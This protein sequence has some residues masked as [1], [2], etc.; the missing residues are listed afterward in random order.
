MKKLPIG[1]VLMGMAAS[2]MGSNYGA[3]YEVSI[4][5]TTKGQAFTPQ[6][7]VTHNAAVRL[8]TLG[9][10]ASEELAILAEGGDTA[11][12]TALLQA[13]GNAVKE[14]KTIG[15]LILPGATATT[16]IEADLGHSLI[17]AAAM[18]IPTNDTFFALDAQRLPLIGS[19]SFLVVG[20]DSGS[21]ANDQNCAS[22]PGP[23]CGG[24]GYSPGTNA[25]DEGFVP[26]GNGF[27]ELGNVAPNGGELLK[28]FTYDWRNPV[29]LIKVRRI[30]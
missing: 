25:G 12:L 1:L 11:P 2:A 22:I 7:V 20:Y 8:F 15:G 29:A 13:A 28:P 27:H 4:T 18:L 10:P 3:T 21:E 9:Q 14:A 17:S 24:Q 23:R 30:R 19:V 16:T 5:N 26:I 6:L